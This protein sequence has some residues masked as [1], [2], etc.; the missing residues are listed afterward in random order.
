[1]Y[2]ASTWP[3]RRS[4]DGTDAKPTPGSFAMAFRWMIVLLAFILGVAIHSAWLGIALAA[5]LWVPCLFGQRLG[6]HDALAHIAVV[7]RSIEDVPSTAH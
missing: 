3:V 7:E 6:V 5:L 1:M 4:A 2:V